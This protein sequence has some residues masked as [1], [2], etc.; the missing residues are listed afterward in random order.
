V[1]SL[2]FGPLLNRII[3]P[4]IRPVNSQVIRPEEKAMLSRLVNIMVSLELRFVQEKTEDG[5]PMYR[6]DPPVDVFVTYEGKRAADIPP[7]RYAVRH[8]VA[9][10]I[11]VRLA[12]R[13]A[14]AF[15]RTKST[16]PSTFFGGA[17]TRDAHGPEK[18]VPPPGEGE[19][20]FVSSATM[21]GDE[22]PEKRIK[23]ACAADADVVEKPATDFF[24]RPITTPKPPSSRQ[25]ATLP[26]RVSFRY[27]EGCSAAVRK[28]TKLSSFL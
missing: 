14:E 8:L 16:K 1:L 12:V 2:E 10:E 6:L 20:T 18:N 5:Q 28:P 7:P 23:T 19:G 24:G 17:T 9:T 3:S 22:P 27:R 25:K 13:N 11:D 21:I 4:P 15:E 26:F